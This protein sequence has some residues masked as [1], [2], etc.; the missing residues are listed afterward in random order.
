M[1]LGYRK[2]EGHMLAY[3]G[4]WVGDTVRQCLKWIEVVPSVTGR[5]VEES[6][7]RSHSSAFCS[8][9]QKSKA[10][11]HLWLTTCGFLFHVL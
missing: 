1:K 3:G 11:F 6:H 9:G 2:Q 5:L 4:P 8:L 7:S 10:E